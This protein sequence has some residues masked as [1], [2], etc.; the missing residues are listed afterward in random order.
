MVTIFNQLESLFENQ[1]SFK[2]LTSY[3]LTTSNHDFQLVGAPNQIGL[4][5]DRIR[6]SLS[7]TK[8][9]L[10]VGG[11]KVKADKTLWQDGVA[12]PIPV[13]PTLAPK[14]TQAPKITPKKVIQTTK[15][16]D[17]DKNGDASECMKCGLC[18]P[19]KTRVEL[20]FDFW[21]PFWPC[22]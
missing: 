5:R 14:T 18:P 20:D 17:A 10:N 4:I 22:E 1:C 3:L 16:P 13:K 19:G 11:T 21:P 2:N 7:H 12:V 9:E 6:D 8:F 15:A